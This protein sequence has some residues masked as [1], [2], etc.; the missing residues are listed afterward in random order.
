MTVKTAES[1]DQSSMAREQH[2]SSTPVATG[3]DVAVKLK[4]LEIEK[5]QLRL[6]REKFE[7][8]KAKEELRRQKE[9][10]AQNRAEGDATSAHSQPACPS[11][12]AS[13]VHCD[14]SQVI[15]S[16]SLDSKAVRGISTF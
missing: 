8:E 14:I 1:V 2:L 15:M 4:Q 9:A 6:E 16:V 7:L 3:E 5:E 13:A 10:G 12:R 11:G